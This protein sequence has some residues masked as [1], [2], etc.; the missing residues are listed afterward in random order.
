[1]LH[2]PP[3]PKFSS[4]SLYDEPFLSYGP[5]FGKV[6]RMTPNDLDMFKVKNT[7]MHVT[8]T[9]EAQI[10]V[11]FALRSAVFELWRNFQKSAPNDH[12]WPWHVQGQK[13]Q[14]ACYIHPRGPCFCLFRSTMSCFRVT[15]LLSEKCTE[16]PQMTLTCPRSKIPICI[17]HTLPRPRFLSVLLYDEQF[18]SYAP[19]SG[20]CTKWP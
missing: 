8:Y 14:Y 9:P 12:K 3:R 13:Y 17:L 5:I 20:K 10:F 2:T 7:N 16:W 4:V 1:M 19:F 18:S 15:P 6:H 11:L